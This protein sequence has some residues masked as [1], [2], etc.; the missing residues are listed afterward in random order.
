MAVS[1]NQSGGAF[2]A[3][4]SIRFMAAFA[5]VISHYSENQ[6]LPLPASVF[7]FL[8]GG[9][10]AVSLFFVLSGFILT[11]TYR[12]KLVHGGVRTFYE[13][14]IARIY[15]VILLGLLMCV[16]VVIYLVHA[17]DASLML[18]WY[19]LKGAIYPALAISLICQLL[20]LN[21]W[22]P[23]SA[24]NQPW[25]GPSD[26]VS[27]E[28]FFYLL[29]PFLVRRMAGLKPARLAFFCIA[30]WLTTGVWIALLDAYMPVSR[31]GA[32]I[33]AM[34]VTRLAEF[35]M[36][37]CSALFYQRLQ[38][39]AGSQH[40][41]GKALVVLALTGLVGLSVWRPV[42]PSFFLDAPFF[43]AL[44]L[45]LALL[46]RPVVGILSWRPL[47][48]LG[49]ASYSLYLTHM[50]IALWSLMIGFG[51]S[52]GWIVIVF[53]VLVSL[54]CFKFYEEPMRKRIKARFADM[55]TRVPSGEPGQSVI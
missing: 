52:N 28:A 41:R 33:Y 4:T 34:P 14:R 22:F 50:P 44:I 26:S 27:C 32:M 15:P 51:R 21:A 29:F 47:V 31:S 48:R 30:L 18:K 53:S 16:P 54:L 49:E 43:A 45:G 13:A 38:A 3:L 11:F 24:I 36:G 6:L 10:S 35:V 37:I 20:L 25:N 7:N 2:P 46:E 55:T 8:D 12:D 40:V 42:S 39:G 9:R 17:G 1:S 23:F 5:V 19:A